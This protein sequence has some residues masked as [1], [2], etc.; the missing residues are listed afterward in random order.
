MTDAYYTQGLERLFIVFAVLGIFLIIVEIEIFNKKNVVKFSVLASA[1]VVGYIFF[2]ELI[3]NL[4]SFITSFEPPP[5]S[6][7]LL[8]I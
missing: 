1:L 7:L 3:P 8:M 6:K 5:P 4:D 2:S